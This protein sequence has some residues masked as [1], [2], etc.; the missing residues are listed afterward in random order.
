MN[1][2]QYHAFPDDLK[3]NIFD[4]KITQRFSQIFGIDRYPATMPVYYEHL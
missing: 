1:L 4:I 3:K 2:I